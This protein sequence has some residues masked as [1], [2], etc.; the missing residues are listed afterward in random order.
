MKKEEFIEIRKYI[1]LIL[2]GVLSY[3]LLNNL[4]IFLGFFK[5][6]YNVMLPFILAVVIAFILN[7]PM[8]KIEKVFE[9][10]PRK[11]EVKKEIFC[12]FSFGKYK[13]SPTEIG[14]FG[15]NDGTRTHDLLITNQLLYRLSHISKRRN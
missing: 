2:I 7:I 10:K 12:F 6:L 13:K 9:K 5:T 14:D 8:S 3:W 4:S 15:A 1:I 11:D